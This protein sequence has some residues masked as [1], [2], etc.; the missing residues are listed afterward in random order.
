MHEKFTGCVSNSERVNWT[1]LLSYDF[2]LRD[3]FSLQ[4]RFQ[5]R[6][7][8]AFKRDTVPISSTS[9]HRFTVS[10]EASTFPLESAP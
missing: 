1:I 7:Y 10:I 8:S 2:V 5:R 4:L 3:Q 9:V 6:T